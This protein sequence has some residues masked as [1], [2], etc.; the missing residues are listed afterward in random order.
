MIVLHCS[1]VKPD[2][3]RGKDLREY[4]EF[5]AILLDRTYSF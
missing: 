5:G 4:R 1:V 2:L 3:I